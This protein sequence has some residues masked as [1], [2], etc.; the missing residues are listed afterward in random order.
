[1]LE[2]ISEEED[3]EEEMLRI[4]TMLLIKAV[5][6]TKAV[7]NLESAKVL[8]ALGCKRVY[9]PET[10]GEMPEDVKVQFQLKIEVSGDERRAFDVYSLFER[11][12]ER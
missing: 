4:L 11:Q 12:K 6:Y 10:G 7:I 2:R 3:A 9:N 1:M 8:S 5:S